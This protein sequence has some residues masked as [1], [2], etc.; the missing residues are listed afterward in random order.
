MALGLVG[1]PC[2][3]A[4]RAVAAA[5]QPEIWRTCAVFRGGD[6]MVPW[7]GQRRRARGQRVPSA[8]PAG[9]GACARDYTPTAD[10]PHGLFRQSRSPSR[11]VLSAADHPRGLFSQPPSGYKNATAG[12]SCG[13]SNDTLAADHPHGLF[14][15]SRSPSRAVLSAADHPRGLFSQ[16]PSGY[17]NAAAGHPCGLSNVRRCR[18]HQPIT[19][20]SCSRP[21]I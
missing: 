19:L 15:Q 3:G 10:H 16:P 14:R 2:L 18:L 11:A 8:L 1:M 5:Q 21:V 13:L 7:V 20:M 9:V 6:A 4:V 12:H 17:M